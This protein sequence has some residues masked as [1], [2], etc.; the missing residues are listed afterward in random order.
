MVTFLRPGCFDAIP[1]TRGSDK[2]W[3]HYKK[4]FT[5]FLTSIAEQEPNNLNVLINYVSPEVFGYIVDC[6]DYGFALETLESLYITLKNEIFVRQLSAARRQ[7]AGESLHE[8][9]N[10]LKL[11]SKDCNFKDVSAENYRTEMIR[12]AFI[13]RL[14]SQHI[15]QRL[16]ENTTLD[17][18][19]AYR[20]ARSLESAKKTRMF[21]QHKVLI[22]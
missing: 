8:F 21:I 22:H 20:Q 16:L 18:D 2:T 4:T 10:V 13:N 17:L 11:L 14:L 15:R 3:L 9:L 12:D 6:T 1:N 7:Q 5:N 19:A